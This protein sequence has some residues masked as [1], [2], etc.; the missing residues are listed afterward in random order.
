MLVDT[1]SRLRQLGVASAHV[2]SV[3][4]GTEGRY[5]FCEMHD[6]SVDGQVRVRQVRETR[7]RSDLDDT[8]TTLQAV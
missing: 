6:S 7:E 1:E 2:V 8:D 3:S 5:L 4:F